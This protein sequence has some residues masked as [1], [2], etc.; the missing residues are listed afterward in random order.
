M[1]QMGEN[2]GIALREAM[3]GGSLSAAS[4]AAREIGLRERLIGGAVARRPGRLPRPDV[5]TLS[6][7]TTQGPW[8]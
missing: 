7:T 5:R 3:C 2:A 4:C 6:R 1:V 8:E